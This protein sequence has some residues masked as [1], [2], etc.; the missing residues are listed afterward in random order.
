VALGSLKLQVKTPNQ[1]YNLPIVAAY[2][3]KTNPNYVDNCIL[4]WLISTT[5]LRWTFRKSTTVMINAKLWNS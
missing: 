4:F 3:G 1:K 2:G 5:H